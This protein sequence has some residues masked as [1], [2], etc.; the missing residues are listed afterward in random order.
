MYESSCAHTVI[1]IR[2][3]QNISLLCLLE[4]P[5][6]LRMLLSGQRLIMRFHLGFRVENRKSG[7]ELSLSFFFF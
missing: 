1:D 5:E 4:L 3:Q 6:D 2:H 7:K